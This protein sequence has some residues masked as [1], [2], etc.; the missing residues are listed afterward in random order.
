MKDTPVTNMYSHIEFQVADVETTGKKPA[1]Y[2]EDSV[3]TF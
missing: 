2:E 1:I 3:S